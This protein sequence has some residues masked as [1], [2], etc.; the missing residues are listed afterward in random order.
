MTTTRRHPAAAS[1][2]EEMRRHTQA[3]PVIAMGLA[4]LFFTGCYVDESLEANAQSKLVA[5]YKPGAPRTLRTWKTAQGERTYEVVD[6]QVILEGDMIMGPVEEFEARLNQGDVGALGVGRDSGRWDMPVKYSFADNIPGDMRSHIELALNRL[7]NQSTAYISFSRC[8][9]LC[10][11]NHIKF[12]Y[13]SGGGCSAH[14]GRRGWPAVNDVNLDDFC[15]GRNASGWN[16]EDEISSIMHEVMH[17]LGVYHMQGRCDRD[18]FIAIQWNNIES[19]RSHNFDQHCSDA[20]DYGAYDFAS[21]MHYPTLAF[22]NGNGPTIVPHDPNNAW[23]IGSQTDLSFGDRNVLRGMYGGKCIPYQTSC[24]AWQ[25]GYVEAGC[26]MTLN[27]G[28]CDPS[29]PDSYCNDGSCCPS[30]GICSNGM[31]CLQTPQ[32]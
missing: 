6:G 11:G 14:V 4:A 31:A 27:C 16:Y 30:S 21:I 5:V 22:T 13:A 26:G 1:K 17:A 8:S 29:C 12:Q 10:A 19:G 24:S 23:L 28:S 18:N 20:T 9:G 3:A 15:D 32:P 2:E 25:C 7:V